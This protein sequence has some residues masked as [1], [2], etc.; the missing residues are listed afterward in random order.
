MSELTS[1]LKATA[2]HHLNESGI[3]KT[4]KAFDIFLDRVK[5]QYYRLT[6]SEKTEF[7]AKWHGE[8]E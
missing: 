2:L 3:E 6:D 7:K 1:M 8:A 4:K 5:T